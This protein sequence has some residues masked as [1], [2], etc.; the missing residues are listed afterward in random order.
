MEAKV[1]RWVAGIGA[2]IVVAGTVAVVMRSEWASWNGT[3]LGD[4]RPN[5]SAGTSPPVVFAEQPPNAGIPMTSEPSSRTSRQAAAAAEAVAEA[6]EAGAPPAPGGGGS[7]TAVA[8]VDQKNHVAKEARAKKR[9]PKREEE[10]LA[11]VVALGEKPGPRNRQWEPAEARSVPA[12]VSEQELD[13][14]LS[15]HPPTA[16]PSRALDRYLQGLRLASYA[17]NTPSP[18][19]VDESFQVHAAVSPALGQPELRALL[20]EKLARP[21]DAISSSVVR[22]APQMKATLDGG[23]V[24]DVSAASGGSDVRELGPSL[25]AVWT[26]NVSP[27]EP[28]KSQPLVLSFYVIPPASVA[29]GPVQIKVLHRRI[30][31]DVTYPWLLDH[32]WDRYWKWLVGGA[33]TVVSACFAWWWRQRFSAPAGP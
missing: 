17:F 9:P 21:G 8:K 14:L 15:S 30:D 7:P 26:W 32:Y 23:G 4:T 20:V 22:Y 27:R 16:G 28:G 12:G 2:A 18:V 24:F 3:L 29:P 25:H 19:R 11:P 6:E 10:Q 31:V 33:A 1:V 13:L 5:A